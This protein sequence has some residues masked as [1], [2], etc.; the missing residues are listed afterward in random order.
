M[1]YNC[2]DDV[3]GTGIGLWDVEVGVDDEKCF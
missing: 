3:P 2:W 1:L